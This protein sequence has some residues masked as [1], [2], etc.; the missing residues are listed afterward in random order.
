MVVFLI[1]EETTEGQK[2]TIGFGSIKI[3]WGEPSVFFGS[4]KYAVILNINFL[5]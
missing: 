3:T 2:L 4:L 1:E 5:G